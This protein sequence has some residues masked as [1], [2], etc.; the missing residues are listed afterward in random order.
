MPAI[1]SQTR[2]VV[3]MS[4]LLGLTA[5]VG[6]L[7]L[8][9]V[10]TPRQRRSAQ[11][12]IM[13]LNQAIQRIRAA[14]IDGRPIASLNLAQIAADNYPDQPDAW[15]WLAITADRFGDANTATQA[16][17][18]QMRLLGGPDQ[19]P[20]RGAERFTG[21]SANLYRLAWGH[22]ILGETGTA[23][24]RFREAADALEN[25]SSP[26]NGRFAQYNLACYRSMAGQ[27]D[28]AAAH[29]A[30]AVDAGYRSDNGWWA[31]DPDLDPI[32]S[33]AVYLDAAR[34]LRER[35]PVPPPSAGVEIRNR[36]GPE[37]TGWAGESDPEPDPTPGDA[38][39]ADG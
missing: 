35:A 20:G 18:R 27:F 31:V 34:R 19:I 37:T 17:E 10:D 4:A 7:V 14:L 22:Q 38:T 24:A 26:N 3:L 11:S 29:L 13:P 8:A 39:P 5:F 25:E 16:A 32:R 1:L 36:P 6:V 12:G 33:H 28:R 21:G 15:M 30:A 2:T 23:R 9:P